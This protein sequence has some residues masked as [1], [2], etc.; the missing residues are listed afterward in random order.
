M[1]K[2][3]KK[4]PEHSFLSPFPP[5]SGIYEVVGD[6]KP[7]LNRLGEAA[8]I[9]FPPRSPQLHES[10]KAK[11]AQA[12]NDFTQAV[13]R[14]LTSYDNRERELRSRAVFDALRL[15]KSPSLIESEAK[16]DAL[17][18]EMLINDLI[19]ACLACHIRQG[20]NNLSINQLQNKIRTSNAR[21]KQDAD[22]KRTDQ[23]VE[24]HVRRLWKQNPKRIGN[25]SGTASDIM[26]PLNESLKQDGLKPLRL[27]AIRK[28]V[29]KI[30][31]S[32]SV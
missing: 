26:K 12:F 22:S 30:I 10:E 5:M 25:V 7:L 8:H 20:A 32:N 16:S 18:K 13:I 21:K 6:N 17:G 23:L 2:E 27:E 28:R 1:T 19:I 4:L 11:M 24:H 3:T 31:K 15:A 14:I 9:L 29:R